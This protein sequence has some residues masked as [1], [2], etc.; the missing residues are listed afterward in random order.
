[1]HALGNWCLRVFLFAL[2]CAPL[3]AGAAGESLVI[4]S[5]PPG[6][7]VEIDG[8]VV[9]TTPY[10]L[11]CPGGYFHKTKTV[12][13]ARL[14]HAMTARVYKDGYTAQEFKLTEGPFEWVALNGRNHG[15]YW[16]LKTN[17]LEA[18]LEPVSRVFNGAIHAAPASFR[19]VSARSELP[20]EQIVETATP[21]VVKLQDAEGWGT[22]FLITDTGII[23]T[24]HH[25]TEGTSTMTVVFSDGTKMPGKVVYSNSA[26]GTDLALVKVEG[27]NFPSLPL[28]RSDELRAGQTV[29]AIGNPGGGMPD[30]VTRGIVSAVGR[31]REAGPGTW[32]QTDANINPGNSGGPLLN[33]YGEVVGINTLKVIGLG[34]SSGTVSGLGFAL[35]SDDLLQLL[36]R[37]YPDADSDPPATAPVGTGSVTIASDV[38][39]ADIYVD[40]KLVGETPSKIVLSMG[41]HHVEVKTSGKQEWVRD[42]DV[43]KDSEVTLRPA[44]GAQ[45]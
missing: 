35:S 11:K 21:A 25:V 37:F 40:G 33:V 30:T 45:P 41:T 28:A 29:I 19:R 3:A 32:I 12:F 38:E 1:M 34:N 22:G 14:E 44:L 27:R 4:K 8:I 26:Q 5:S 24:N 17:Q 18:S 10:E 23:A 15:H 6:A 13:G 39:G 9:G 20:L 31:D 42:L 2:W 16:L 7:T 36:Q 43:T